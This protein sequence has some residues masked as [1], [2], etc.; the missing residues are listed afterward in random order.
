MGA[1]IDSANRCE[2]E[3][4][5]LLEAVRN[6]AQI[7]DVYW[8]YFADYGG[9]VIFVGKIANEDGTGDVVSILEVTQLDLTGLRNTIDEVLQRLQTPDD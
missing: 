6:G 7:P 5:Y 1:L 3:E 2:R 9:R 8:S 4:T